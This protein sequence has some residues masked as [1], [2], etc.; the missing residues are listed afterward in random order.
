VKTVEPG[1]RVATVRSVAVAPGTYALGPETATL[2]VRTG[3]AGAAARAGHDLLIEVTAWS[4]TLRI[5]DAPEETS[6]RLRADPG[7][8]RVRTGSGGLQPLGDAD[9]R[10][11]EQRIAGE[12]L[13]SDPI[14]FRSAE[15]QDPAGDGTL[16]IGG[17]LDLVGIRRPLTF[18]LHL[19]S[20]GRLAATATVTQTRWGITPYAVLFGTLKVLDDVTVEIEGRLPP[21]G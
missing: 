3:R 6:V 7:S 4:A 2:T 13:G 9:R 17:E 10:R 12:V 21:A 16:R 15:A 20:D 14:A 1:E 18:T 5:G 8:L 19:G 11:I